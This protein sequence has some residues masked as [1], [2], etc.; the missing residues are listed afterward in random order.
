MADIGTISNPGNI[1]WNFLSQLVASGDWISEPADTTSL[2]NA[3]IVSHAV[4]MVSGGGCMKTMF[5]SPKL[6]F[7]QKDIA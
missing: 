2:W 3:H 7:C 5:V 4:S 6:R 1:P